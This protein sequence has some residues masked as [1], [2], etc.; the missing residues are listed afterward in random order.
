MHPAFRATIHCLCF[1]S[2]FFPT[3]T[4]LALVSIFYQDRPM[5]PLINNL[6]SLILIFCIHLFPQWCKRR[7]CLPE[8]S[9]FVSVPFLESW[10]TLF[11]FSPRLCLV[12]V[13][14]SILQA[15]RQSCELE[16]AAYHHCSWKTS[17]LTFWQQMRFYQHWIPWISVHF[18]G[19]SS[20]QLLAGKIV[21]MKE[22]KTCKFCKRW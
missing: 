4:A 19:P 12:V 5:Y 11:F 21:K 13:S 15:I 16:M 14:L 2:I 3:L 7:Y 22:R 10:I 8:M 6:F 20:Y 18:F 1:P 9:T 17:Y